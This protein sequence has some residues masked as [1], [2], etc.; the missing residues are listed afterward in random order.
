MLVKL[1]VVIAMIAI[2]VTLLLPVMQAARKDPRCPSF[3][4]AY[5][6]REVSLSEN[7]FPS[8]SLGMHNHKSLLRKNASGHCR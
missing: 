2:L 1:L 8:W 7:A 4:S 6:F 3:F 5:S